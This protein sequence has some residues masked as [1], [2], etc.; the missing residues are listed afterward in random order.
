[1]NKVEIYTGNDCHFCH[2]AMDFFKENNIEYTEFNVSENKEARKF[3][4][5]KGVMSVPFIVIDDNELRGF[6]KEAVRALIK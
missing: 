4:M 3:L 2:E 1:M 6:D 5:K